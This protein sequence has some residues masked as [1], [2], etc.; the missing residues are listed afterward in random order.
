MANTPTNGIFMIFGRLAKIGLKSKVVAN[1]TTL[2]FII[3]NDET[4]GGDNPP[5][6][7]TLNGDGKADMF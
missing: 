3:K 6:N 4:G 7:C 1:I 2:L 5:H